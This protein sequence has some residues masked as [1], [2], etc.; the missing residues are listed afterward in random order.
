[1]LLPGLR[2]IAAMHPHELSYFSG[3]VGGVKGAERLGLELTYW[4]E[5]YRAAL[6]FLNA[7]PEQSPSVWTEED[8]VLY[9]YR[10]RGQLRADINVGG[11]VVKAGPLAATYAL[12]QRRP[13][14]YTPEIEML[15]RNRQPVFV[16]RQDGMALAYVFKIGE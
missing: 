3:I 11:R 10:Q 1:M 13:S 7:V 9:T 12:I 15:V 5:T 16:V 4:C 6:P 2:G 14:G 8:G